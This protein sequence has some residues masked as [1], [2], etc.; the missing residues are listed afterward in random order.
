MNIIQDL[1]LQ[2]KIG[3]IAQKMIYWNVAFFA[4]P[5]LIF[6][7]LGWFAPKIDYTYFV[8]LSSNPLDLLWKPWSLLSYSFFHTGVLHIFFNMMVL[9][10]AGR[11]F[12]TYF[13]S[14]QFLGLYILSGLFAGLIYL[15]VF[16]VL[17]I[18]APILGASAAIMGILVAT[19]T[20]QPLMELRLLLIGTVKL[21]HVT[22]FILFI[23]L[24]QLQLENMGGHISHLAGAFFGFI[25]IKL[26]QN[27]TDLSKIVSG[28]I[29]FFS[30]LFRKSEPKP[31]RKVH[32]NYNNKPIEKSVSKI[33]TKDRT[34][35]QIDEILDKISQSGYDCLTKEEKEFLFKAGK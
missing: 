17:K 12:M 22:A 26:L 7:I 31:F 25:F 18:D 32:K 2:Y 34:Q 24:I 35:Q 8:S 15:L 33:V 9:N 3:S 11:L 20:Y 13:T 5:S 27:G 23:D 10:F 19:T 21:W 4:I 29:G 16:Y 1:K 28:V 30:N 6:M 14:K